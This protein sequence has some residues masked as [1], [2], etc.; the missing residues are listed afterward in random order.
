[1]SFSDFK[2]GPMWNISSNV[3]L[4][5]PAQPIRLL[6]MLNS[7]H[8]YRHSSP[9]ALNRITRLV[10]KKDF[11]HSRLTLFL[12]WLPSQLFTFAHVV[13]YTV[14]VLYFS[15]RIHRSDRNIQFHTPP[16]LRQFVQLIIQNSSAREDQISDRSF[17][18][19]Y[20]HEYYLST[21]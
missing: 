7:A 3:C 17:L 12:S 8:I 4:L 19:K 10:T 11:P 5:P 15:C 20:W 21:F 13:F 1:M 14:A 6:V 2:L 9:L 18:F 16:L